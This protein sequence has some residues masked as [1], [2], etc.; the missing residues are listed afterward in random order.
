MI[1]KFGHY[2][3]INHSALYRLEKLTF[4]KFRN[5]D[6]MEIDFGKYPI[7]G[8]F[9]A[10]GM[11]K[12]TIL[13]TI[14]CLYQSVY[15]P[16]SKRGRPRKTPIVHRP[17]ECKNEPFGHL[18]PG[19][20]LFNYIGSSIVADFS[21]PTGNVS[22]L[23]QIQSGMKR[24]SPG[25]TA[26]PVR[27][28]YYIEMEYCIPAAEAG[29]TKAARDKRARIY[30]SIMSHSDALRT[31]FNYIFTRDISINDLADTGRGVDEQVGIAMSGRKMLFRD[32]SAGEQ[33]VLKLL[34]IIY[35]APDGSIILID[36]IELTLHKYALHNLLDVLVR[37]A[38]KRELQVIFTSHNQSLLHR[39]DIN[40][41]SLYK[42]G[43]RI[44]CDH[45]Y[46]QDC[47][48]LLEGPDAPKYATILVED[49][50]S[51][52]IVT[53]LLNQKD[54]LRLASIISFGGYH[55][56]F[57]LASSLYLTEK[58]SDKILFVL[59]GD[60]CKTREEKEAELQTAK[61]IPNLTQEMKDQ[62]LSHFTEYILPDGTTIEPM[63]YDLIKREQ[64]MTDPVVVAAN[65]VPKLS[66]ETVPSHIADKDKKRYLE[67]YMIPA[68]LANLGY[69]GNSVMVGYLMIVHNFAT[70]YPKKWRILTSKLSK[71]IDDNLC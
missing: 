44:K 41:R 71:W 14:R 69:R 3:L 16:R 39:R 1:D 51:Q 53:E 8:I 49:M 66:M 64:D 21:S 6:G 28:V 52:T 55:D 29:Y 31:D 36:E 65:K 9:G 12:S 56:A 42:E 63:L 61:V 25:T 10:N 48:A 59:D 67:H 15:N 32:L 35:N 46:N 20:H 24:W 17:A 26:K 22:G 27:P 13:A 18:F 45:G 68:T 70:N 54:K 47:I 23:Y 62:I 58:L 33:R 7:T 43:E 19:N 2:Y 5:L 11:G 37:M 4:V 38:H 50:M 57:K 34:D 40:I 60:V 30:R